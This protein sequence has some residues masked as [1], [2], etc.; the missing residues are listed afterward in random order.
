MGSLMGTASSWHLIT[1]EYPPRPGGVADYT[2]QLAHALSAAGEEVH[3]WTP[4]SSRLRQDGRVLIHGVSGFGPRGLRQLSALL[5]NLPA[6]KRLFVQYVAP[7]F[8]LRGV[9]LPF[10]LWLAGR[11]EEEVWIQFHEVAHDFSFHQPL[12]HNGLALVQCWMAQI[13]AKRA[14]R[15]FISVPG[16]RRQLGHHGPRAEVLPIP[17]NLPV[18]IAQRH[19]DSVRARLGTAPVVG[20]FGTYGPLVRDL[21]EPAIL[22][23]LLAVPD[24]RVLLLGRGSLDFAAHFASTSPDV[25]SRIIASGALEAAS[26]SAHLA[27]CDVLIQ[28]YPDGI[29]GRRT[30]AMAGLALG[31]PLVTTIGHLTEEEWNGSGAVLMTPVG[32]AEE[33]AQAVARLLAYP[34]ER[35][36]LR[37]RGRALYQARFSIAHTL[38]VLGVRDSSA[39]V[40]PC[41]SAR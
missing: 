10:C 28:P 21:L 20:H 15:L 11:V 25:T 33:V 6:P 24:A 39:K 2:H 12:R 35:E 27:A 5:G 40:E 16:W 41:P 22:A 34:S 9:N 4:S 7:A 1:G 38:D 3:V 36:A 30:S 26:V 31:R 8:G 17:S 23:V 29:S 37:A 18:D 13:V 32:R 19:V 14:Q